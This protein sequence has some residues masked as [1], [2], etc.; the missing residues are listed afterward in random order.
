[1]LGFVP[2]GAVS[3]LDVG[4]H[5]GGFGQALR[6]DD[7]ARILWAVEADEEAAGAARAHYDELV[8]GRYPEVLT[9][10]EA[11]FDCVVFN[12]SLEHMV[13]PWAALRATL[14]L[15]AAGGVVVASIPNVRHLKVVANLVLRGDWTYTDLGIL[16]RT[17]LRFFTAKTIRALFAESGFVVERME[18]ISAL[19][20]LRG[21]FWRVLPLL[22]G[23]FAYTGFAVQARPAGAVR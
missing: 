21:R 20:H 12:D 11:Q 17:H 7:P 19:G 3:V 22:L 6:R 2:K 8:L 9:G 13:D 18:G 23:D 1:M 10:T 16:D 15:L 4:C 5:I 14:P